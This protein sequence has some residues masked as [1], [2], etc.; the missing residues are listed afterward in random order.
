VTLFESWYAP[1]VGS[2]VRDLSLQTSG[3]MRERELLE[4]RLK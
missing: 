3:A 4:Y 2:F 1:Q